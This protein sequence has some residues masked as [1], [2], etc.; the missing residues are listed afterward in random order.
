MIR[1][2]LF[3][4]WCSGLGC[5][6]TPASTDEV[7][8]ESE[9]DPDSDVD[10]KSGTEPETD[11]GSP[12]DTGPTAGPA[13]TGSLYIANRADLTVQQFDLALGMVVDTIFLP[14]QPAVVWPQDMAISPNG[15]RLALPRYYTIDLVDTTTHEVSTL[16]T[17]GTIEIMSSVAF[18]TPDV[19]VASNEWSESVRVFE[20]ADAGLPEAPF[21]FGFP[22]LGSG[23]SVNVVDIHPTTGEVIAAGSFGLSRFSAAFAQGLG[24]E[25]ATDYIGVTCDLLVP[26]DMAVLSNGDVFL[27]CWE[28]G[29]ARTNLDS[30]VTQEIA[31]EPTEASSFAVSPDE[32]RMLVLGIQGAYVLDVAT[33]TYV[34]GPIDVGV[35]PTGATFID[36]KTA[37]TVAR[38]NTLTLLDLD[39]LVTTSFPNV[40]NWPTEIVFVP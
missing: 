28:V 30:S 18:S 27:P 32:S 14:A 9:S 26:L 20:V 40:G 1:G 15:Q 24:S 5:G 37:A 7:G 25:D 8:S 23:G 6:P 17:A 13:P 34:A 21:S 35:E 22:V 11:T 10:P 33:N 12:V 39:T 16:S 3:F 38:G 4:L 31:S 29:L 19:V 2:W 36:D